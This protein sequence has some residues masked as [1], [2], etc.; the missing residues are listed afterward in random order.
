M[1]KIN[2]RFGDVLS[3]MYLST[4]ILKRFQDNGCKKDEEAIAIHALKEQLGKAQIALEGLYQNI[5]PGLGRFILF[6]FAIWAR[7]NAFVCPASDALGHKVVKNF[8]K[9]SE[10]RDELTNGIYISRDKTDNLGRLENALLLQEKAQKARDKIKDAIKTRLLP[11]ERVENLIEEAF[12]KSVINLEEK[13]QLQTAATEVLDA[14][15]V[16]EYS[17]EDYKKI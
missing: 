13:Q 17:L 12:T 9:N 14:M 8:I 10:L 4:C 5:F 3:A 11:R 16:D 6:P 7:I 1:E 15:Q 2:G